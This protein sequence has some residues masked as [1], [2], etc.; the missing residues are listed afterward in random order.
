LA[1]AKAEHPGLSG[2]KLLPAG[3]DSFLLR[4]EMAAAAMRALDV[5]YFLIQSDDTGQLRFTE[6]ARPANSYSCC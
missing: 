6:I 4:M 5:E 2:F 1:S 3:T